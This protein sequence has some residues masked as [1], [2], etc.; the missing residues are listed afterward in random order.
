[1]RAF[2]TR[3]FGTKKPSLTT[4]E[5]K[6][7]DVRRPGGHVP[8]GDELA[9]AES[10]KLYSDFLKDDHL[11]KAAVAKH[12]ARQA[13]NEK[14]FDDAWRL[15]HEQQSEWLAHVNREKFTTRQMFALLSSI[16]MDMANIL[17]LEGKHDEALAHVIYSAAANARPTK[18]QIKKLGVYFRRCRFD[19]RFTDTQAE[20]AARLLALNPD[21]RAAQIQVSQWRD[22]TSK[23]IT[24]DD[25]DVAGASDKW[26][27][28]MGGWFELNFAYDREL[29]PKIERMI[30]RY[31]SFEERKHWTHIFARNA[32]V[33]WDGVLDAKGQSIPFNYD[34]AAALIADDQ[35]LF[36]GLIAELDKEPK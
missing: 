2:L 7:T 33:N 9:E 22:G 32:L 17:R 28:V 1:M 21:Y 15:L 29:V 11:G 12:S 35:K 34:N 8:S 16:H 4:E 3:L 5:R 19:E 31:E 10:H 14:R 30:E 25:I 13:V 24:H 18:E 27:A 23:V 6:K 20:F 36:Y 26:V